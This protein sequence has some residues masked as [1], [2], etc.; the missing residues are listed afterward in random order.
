MSMSGMSRR[1]RAVLAAVGVVA[2]Y[3]LAALLFF[4]GRHKAWQ[5]AERLYSAEVAKLAKENKLIARTGYWTERDEK[6]RLQMPEVEEGESTQVR[7]QRLHDKLAG[8]YNVTIMKESPK[9]EEDHGGV[10]EMPIEVTYEASLVRLVEFLHALG[11]VEG[12]MFDVR[13]L[14][15][16]PKNT[17]FLTGKY[18]LTCAYMKK[19]GSSK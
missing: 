11:R 14:D 3:G 7:W 12:A 15:I 6:T 19:K 9:E 2:L 17:G 18:T 16:S 8:E 13:D 1:D 5:R 4:T 10:W